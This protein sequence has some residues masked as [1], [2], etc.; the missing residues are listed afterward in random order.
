[1]TLKE[2]EKIIED[3]IKISTEIKEADLDIENILKII[4]K[5]NEDIS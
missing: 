4:I 5:I 1:M 2:L 3:E